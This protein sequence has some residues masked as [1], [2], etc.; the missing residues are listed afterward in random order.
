M[1]DEINKFRDELFSNILLDVFSICFNV[2][3]NE[4]ITI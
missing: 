2:L 1:F 4:S 3:T